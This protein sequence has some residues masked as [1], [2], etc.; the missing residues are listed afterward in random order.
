M[1]DHRGTE[2]YS[3]LT[4]QLERAITH[5]RPAAALLEKEEQQAAR[6]HAYIAQGY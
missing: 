1:T 3:E 6:D 4:A 2:R 5:H